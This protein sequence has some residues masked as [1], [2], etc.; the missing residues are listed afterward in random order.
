MAVAPLA[1]WPIREVVCDPIPPKTNVLI[2]KHPLLNV[3]MPLLLK[4]ALALFDSIALLKR[5]APRVLL[6][7]NI[8]LH[9]LTFLG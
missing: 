2:E 7:L 4:M 1:L 9:P 8:I 3:K 6:P 5:Q